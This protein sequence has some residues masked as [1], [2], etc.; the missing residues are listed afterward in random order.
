MTARLI[1]YSQPLPSS[2]LSEQNT[3][4]TMQTLQDLV[5]Y[6]ARVSNPANQNNTKTNEKLIHYLIKND[7]KPAPK[8]I[9]T[10]K[11]VLYLKMPNYKNFGQKSKQ[12]LLTKL[13]RHIIWR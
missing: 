4:H 3:V 13:P 2:E 1:S 12:I 10:D 7:E 11:I 9:K 5:A 8:I 6:C